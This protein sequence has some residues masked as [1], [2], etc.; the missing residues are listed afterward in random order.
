MF[1]RKFI[2]MGSALLM[3]LAL[4]L[5]VAAIDV[6]SASAVTAV[7]TITPTSG[8]TG[9]GTATT[10]T[11]ADFQGTCTPAGASAIT[12]VL[13]GATA[14]TAVTVVN[15]TTLTATAPAHVAGPVTVSVSQPPANV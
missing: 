7:S 3:I 15:N 8:G 13:F 11:G 5:P 9:G 2:R 6:P 14:A 10:I 4:T 1:R 12:T